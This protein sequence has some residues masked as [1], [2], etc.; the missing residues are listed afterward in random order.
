MLP[1]AASS[2]SAGDGLAVGQRII[3][4]TASFGELS[5]QASHRDS[6]IRR[7][8]SRTTPRSYRTLLEIDSL[9]TVKR[10]SFVEASY[11]YRR[12]TTSSQRLFNQ[13]STRTW[14]SSSSADLGNTTFHA[15]YA[16]CTDLVRIVILLTRGSL[17][18]QGLPSLL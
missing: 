17:R 9:A 15:H 3:I 13:H 7:T 6:R 18:F 12:A 8:I 4:C 2:Q 10:R 11:S 5:S 1:R 14:T 16:L